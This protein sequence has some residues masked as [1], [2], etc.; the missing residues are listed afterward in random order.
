MKVMHRLLK[1]A[2]L[3]MLEGIEIN[4]KRHKWSLVALALLFRAS[5]AVTQNLSLTLQLEGALRDKAVQHPS[6][7]R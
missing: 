5:I 1:S 6:L 3:V 7:P 4:R 2:A